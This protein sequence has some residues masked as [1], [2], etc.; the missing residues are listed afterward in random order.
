MEKRG[1]LLLCLIMLLP[2]IALIPTSSSVPAIFPFNAPAFAWGVN[3]GE[4]VFY[5][6]I[7]V[8]YASWINDGIVFKF[9]NFTY[10]GDLWSSI[11][12]AAVTPGSTMTLVDLGVQVSYIQSGGVQRIWCPTRGIPSGIGGGTM[13]W[14]AGTSIV[15][16]TTTGAGVVTLI[17]GGALP[18]P[19]LDAIQVLL[20]SGNFFGAVGAF[21]S[22][23]YGL[24]FPGLIAFT[25]S[26]ILYIR[27]QDIAYALAAW[28][29]I[30]GTLVTFLPGDL[31][32]V[33]RV[34]TVVG[35][36]VL[37]IKV[38]LGRNSDSG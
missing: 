15:T 23:R 9:S 19:P 8:T 16:V 35:M 24:V 10:N 34:L 30:G 32:N 28:L 27:G 38:F 25:I 26:A 12:F 20:S 13:T 31:I 17:W 21:Y 3:F 18:P 33:A 2:L 29:L 6:P 14:N 37:I 22:L 36:S 11:G 1:Y 7:P 5:M 4:G